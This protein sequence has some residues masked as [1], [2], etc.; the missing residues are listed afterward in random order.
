MALTDPIMKVGP[1]QETEY[2]VT[3]T[4]QC[5]EVLTG[6]TVIDVE[7]VHVDIET[8]SRG[9]DD[10]YLQAATL[11]YALTWVWDMGDGS[12]YRN[13]DVTHSY[14]D[15]DEHWATLTITTANGCEGVDSVLL[16]PPGHI[17]FPSAF[18]P[19]GDG[20]NDVWGAVG[21]YIEEFELTVFDRWGSAV[22]STTDVMIPWDGKING[23]GQPMSGMY[24][25]KY[26][27]AG[28]L[29]PNM[30]GFGHVTLLP[31]TQPK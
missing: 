23:S 10:W 27:A 3:V 22:F 13:H 14:V 4:D 6:T 30:E 7:H 17:Y 11:P 20:I 9:Q 5:G 29:F 1:M 19:D 26:K 31:G 16:R 28:H 24:V 25:Y 21:H 8:T 18:T 12:R 15:L 2:V